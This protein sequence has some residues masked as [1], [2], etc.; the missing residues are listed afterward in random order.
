[1]SLRIVLA[2]IN[3]LVG[4]IDGN[5][6]RMMDAARRAAHGH[7]ARLVVFP[8]LSLTGYPPEDL[9]LR[10][11]LLPRVEAALARLDA[12]ARGESLV[13]VVGAPKMLPSG[14]ANGA[15]VLGAAAPASYAKQHLPNY[16]VFD[17]HRYFQA[18]DRPLV[19]TVDGV[20][21]GIV[22]CEDIWFPGPAAQARA[23]GAELLL[24]LNASPFHAGK[25]AER[26][27]VVRDRVRE[28]GLPVA[29]VNLV[30]GQ[31]ELVFDGGSFVLARDGTVVAR[32]PHAGEA[33]LPV[34]FSGGDFLPGAC[35]PIPS[36]DQS[37]YDALV[38]G[39]RDYIGKNGFRGALL[40]LS[41]GIDSALTVAI[42]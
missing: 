19:V 9:L 20:R 28:A 11:S 23:A 27:Q 37:V 24:A 12:F 10:R 6:G 3:L 40:G 4:D 41:G 22:I 16:R 1:M 31:D 8:E 32:A 14:L 17:E 18:G 15:F 42:A 38:L 35:A 39:V 13:L 5:A 33:L 36:D 34:D 26:E 25:Q 2:Q 29:Y 7:G 30:G 21:A